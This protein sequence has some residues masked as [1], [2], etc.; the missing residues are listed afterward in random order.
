MSEVGPARV[1]SWCAVF[2][3]SACFCFAF[4]LCLRLQLFELGLR[5]NAETLCLS[6]DL[7]LAPGNVRAYRTAIE[8]LD[9]AL[10]PVP[11]PVE[12]NGNLQALQADVQDSIREAKEIIARKAIDKKQEKEDADHKA[13]LGGPMQPAV[14]P[15]KPVVVSSSA[16]APTSASES[17]FAG[18][19]PFDPMRASSSSGAS[20]AIAFGYD[21]WYG[22]AV[23]AR[24][25]KAC[26]EAASELGMWG[27]CV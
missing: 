24:A 6:L 11:M 4:A 25:W 13:S 10:S 23:P 5:P 26:I 9:H 20:L 19:V 16:A 27:Q 21:A 14:D 15:T 3:S 12:P 2:F 17:G 8:L 18:P 1:A 7:I 22:M